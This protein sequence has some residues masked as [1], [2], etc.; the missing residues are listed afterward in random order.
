[1]LRAPVREASGGTVQM[2]AATRRNLEL[3]QALSGGREGSLL[4]VID[5]TVTSAGARLLEARLGAPS[6]DVGVIRARQAAL[7]WVID[8]DRHG[9]RD[10]LTGRSRGWRWSAA[11]R[12]IW[13]RSGRGCRRRGGSRGWWRAG[14]WPMRRWSG[15]TG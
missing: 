11:G 3:V 5:R 1:L 2:D 6:R 13:Q 4:S 9:L 7:A 10:A 15:M 12:G 8:G 14:L